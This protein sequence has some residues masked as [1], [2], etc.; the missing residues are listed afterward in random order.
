MFQVDF[1]PY[2]LQSWRSVRSY[3]LESG[4]KT[5]NLVEANNTSIHSLW[6]AVYGPNDESL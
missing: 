2:Q 5:C 3:G 6:P 4:H 1:Q